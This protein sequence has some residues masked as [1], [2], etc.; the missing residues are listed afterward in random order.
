MEQIQAAL[1][2]CGFDPCEVYIPAGTYTTSPISTWKNKDETGS[3]AGIALPSNVE[4]RGAGPGR[5]VINVTRTATDPSATLF[6]NANHSNRNIRLSDM[7]IT[8]KD[9]S[10]KY[11]W[12][13]IFICHR[14]EQLELDGLSLE[15]NPNK[16]VNLLDNTGIN[17]SRQRILVR[18][19]GYGH[20]DNALSVNRFDSA[21]FVGPVAGVVRD[22]RFAEIGDYRAPLHVGRDAIGPVRSRQ[23]F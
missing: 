15:G 16:L 20:G 12:V 2:D 14:C 22:N 11:D 17:V 8:W 10:Q 19:T 9:S 3:S 4:I 18:S 21:A 23:H 1:H 6:A 7:S 5:T 13:S